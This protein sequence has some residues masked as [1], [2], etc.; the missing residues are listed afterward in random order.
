MIDFGRET[1]DNTN[2]CLLLV[3]F[4]VTH[5]IC[6]CLKKHCGCCLQAHRLTVSGNFKLN[7]QACRK[8][9]TL[10]V[11]PAVEEL[12]SYFQQPEWLAGAC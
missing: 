11:R 10:S 12:I 7:I 2:C 4:S 9:N 5:V 1:S 3:R 8:I 6:L